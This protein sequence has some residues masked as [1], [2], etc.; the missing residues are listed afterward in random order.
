[1]AT[2]SKPPALTLGLCLYSILK[3]H[4]KQLVHMSVSSTEHGITP[5]VTKLPCLTLQVISVIYSSDFRTRHKN[6][7]CVRPLS[8]YVASNPGLPRLD[9]I[10]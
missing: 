6:F 10:S 8:T 3:L 9:F 1:M 7:F 2:L 4:C 5:F